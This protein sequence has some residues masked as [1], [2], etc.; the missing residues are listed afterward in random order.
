MHEPYLDIHLAVPPD[1]RTRETVTAAMAEQGADGFL[2][3][4]QGLHCYIPRSQWTGSMDEALR[5]IEETYGVPGVQCLSISVV[6]ERNWNEEW[7][8]SIRP[9]AVTDRIIIAPSWHPAVPPP[10]G[11]VLTIDPKMTFGTGYHETTRLML[12]LMERHLVPGGTVLDVGTGTGVL[13][14]AAVKMGASSALGVDI[15]EW[16]ME[17]GPENAARNGAAGTVEFRL[18]SL[19]V[20]PERSFGLILAN[21]I[22]TTIISL[23]DDMASRLAPGGTLL[24]SGL[25]TTDREPIDAALAQRGLAVAEALQEN[26]WIGLAVRA[27]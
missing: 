14:I 27:R 8:R 7:E 4:E 16:T 13:A 20:V 22:R 12:R 25:L 5:E 11:M 15:D 10:G 24:L 2:E 17:N 19:S 9:I 3:D 23:L 21:I 6:E 18:G 26:E 1:E